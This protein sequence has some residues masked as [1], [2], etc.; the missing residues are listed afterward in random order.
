[1]TTRVSPSMPFNCWTRL[2]RPSALW[3]TSKGTRTTSPKGRSTATVLFLLETSIP[4]AFM[5]NTPR[6]NL[7]WT[8]AIFSHCRFHL[9]AL[10]STCTNRTL[11]TGGWLTDFETDVYVLGGIGQTITSPFYSLGNEMSPA[12]GWLPYL[13]DKFI[14]TGGGQWRPQG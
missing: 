3:F 13:R 9:F 5:F 1:M 10:G 11:R 4:A 14:V 8:K 7:Q 2:A 6:M 12:Y